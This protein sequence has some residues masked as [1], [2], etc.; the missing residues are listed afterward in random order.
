MAS[1]KETLFVAINKTVDEMQMVIKVTTTAIDFLTEFA[2]ICLPNKVALFLF[3]IVANAEH[4]KTATVTVLIPP[5][6]PTGD[7]P[8]SIRIIEIIAEAFVRFS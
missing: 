1:I 8:I 6:V 4:I 3:L 7:P 5:A 2:E